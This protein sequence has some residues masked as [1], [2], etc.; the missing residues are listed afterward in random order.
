MSLLHFPSEISRTPR[1]QCT[2]S[3][4]SEFRMRRRQKNGLYRK[5]WD[6]NPTTFLIAEVSL[7]SNRFCRTIICG[8]VHYEFTYI[9]NPYGIM[10]GITC[11][12]TC[13]GDPASLPPPPPPP[14]PHQPTPIQDISASLLLL[15]SP[16]QQHHTPSNPPFPL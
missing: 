9:R 11:L 12:Q 10:Y 13:T 4:S 1:V 3:R 8:I 16:H 15:T 2:G 7:Y 5:K 14:P 6:S